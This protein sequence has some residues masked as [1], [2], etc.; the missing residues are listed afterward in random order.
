M[1]NQESQAQL[2][3]LWAEAVQRI[4]GTQDPQKLYPVASPEHFLRGGCQTGG[5]GVSFL[6]LLHEA[7]LL[8]SPLPL[9]LC[10]STHLQAC[11]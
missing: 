8:S 1:G 7:C 2:I 9:L 4:S 11:P 3:K 6:Q 10:L 5:G